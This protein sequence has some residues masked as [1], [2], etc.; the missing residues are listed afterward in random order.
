[1]MGLF[2]RNTRI[3]QENGCKIFVKIVFNSII[4]NFVITTAYIVVKLAMEQQEVTRINPKFVD[5][6]RWP[7]FVED[8]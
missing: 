6:G 4:G 2:L 1:M 5:I 3:S 8:A 7:S